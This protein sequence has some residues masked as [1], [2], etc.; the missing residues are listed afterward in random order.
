MVNLRPL[1]VLIL[2]AGV[3][4][5]ALKASIDGYETTFATNHLGHFYLTYLLL[6]KLRESA[7]SRLVV[8][9]SSSHAHTGVSIRP[10][11]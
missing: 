10:Y 7:P 4:S 5:P 6:D 9:S 1:H 2:S 8:V 11:I 3:F